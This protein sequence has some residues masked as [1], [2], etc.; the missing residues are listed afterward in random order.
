MQLSLRTVTMIC[1]SS[2]IIMT[3][4]ISLMVAVTSTDLALDKTNKGQ[5]E[6]VD[7]CFD[8]HFESTLESHN[9]VMTE[10]SNVVSLE[11]QRM[12]DVARIAQRD[13][14][15]FLSSVDLA[16][17]GSLT[18]LKESFDLS[19][20]LF[21]TRDLTTMGYVSS[22]SIGWV[23]QS[24][25]QGLINLHKKSSFMLYGN[26]TNLVLGSIDY[27]TGHI[28]D[29]P[30]DMRVA[31]HD[32]TQQSGPCVFPSNGDLLEITKLMTVGE[33]FQ[34]G[35]T[36]WTAVKAEGTYAG[37]S[38]ATP[39]G[40][41]D[42][43]TFVGF[44]LEA[45]TSFLK[46]VQQHD[47]ERIFITSS[48]RNSQLG[49]LI[50][51]SA[52]AVTESTIGV[53]VL[54]GLPNATVLSVTHCRNSTDAIISGTCNYMYQQVVDDT[55]DPFN[56]TYAVQLSTGKA[57]TMDIAI[58]NSTSPFAVWVSRLSDEYGL[59][60]WVVNSV[61]FNHIVG[62][63]RRQRLHADASLH[64]TK[65]DT[66]DVLKVDRLILFLTVAGTAC[67]LVVLAFF[68]ASYVTQPLEGLSLDMH[69]VAELRLDAVS[70]MHGLSI[71]T[72]V[73]S[74]EK[75]FRTMLAAMIEYRQY[76]PDGFGV[77]DVSDTSDDLS[78]IKTDLPSSASDS[79]SRNPQVVY[80]S[81]TMDG[82]R[83]HLS[84]DAAVDLNFIKFAQP[85][86]TGLALTPKK[87][88]SHVRVGTRDFQK[89]VSDNRE[90]TFI[91]GYHSAWLLAVVSEAKPLRGTV[92]RFVG[93]NIDITFGAQQSCTMPSTKAAQFCIN[94]RESVP[95][96]VSEY[97][98]QRSMN[99]T[100]EN[101]MVVGVSTGST[102][103]GN[104]GCQGFKAPS[105][106]GKCILLAKGM[107]AV[108][109]DI[110]LDVVLDERTV[111]DMA[112]N[113]ITTPVDMLYYHG[114]D[115]KVT[116]SYLRGKQVKDDDTEWMYAIQGSDVT[117]S[118][119]KIAWA[120][121]K[122][123]DLQTALTQMSEIDNDEIVNRVVKRLR[124]F[125]DDV[126]AIT[127]ETPSD[128]LKVQTVS[129]L[130]FYLADKIES[131]VPTDNP[132]PPIVK[133]NTSIYTGG[134]ADAVVV[135]HEGIDLS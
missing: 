81:S 83:R 26:E 106:L 38:L 62:D 51:A 46:T 90:P 42:S 86:F 13:A 77:E 67:C 79:Q 15:S 37:I 66:D 69:H 135:S 95:T 73:Y 39:I 89:F 57:Q 10:R 127:G 78:D 20:T 64:Q 97:L 92:E 117:E 119:Y 12:L 25:E 19:L 61:D 125:I 24:S 111:D 72:E 27:T 129:N 120:T 113:F 59:D 7:T 132:L 56:E 112:G 100:S 88:V 47:S 40:N 29:A 82:K 126:V 50:G 16:D 44:S 36:K 33:S 121:L 71:L 14:V 124:I 99:L 76:L 65:T 114:K 34:V 35:Q 122:S 115:S 108:A 116:C 133:R 9:F 107:Q 85:G 3:A 131:I 28:L 84:G 98:C 109:K 32:F 21:A 49:A 6:V 70:T 104:L 105:T 96:T 103:C 128:Y 8:Q 17:T 118:P 74:M 31:L 60:W 130:P 53:D 48:G 43:L 102:L 2:C 5:R 91:V 11:L 75:S 54:S 101:L 1:V 52:G 30:C 123:G 4:I 58:G 22:H 55:I 134:G 94:I 41:T 68:A 63:V 87:S 45:V 18:K 23:F 93:D 80:D 110:G